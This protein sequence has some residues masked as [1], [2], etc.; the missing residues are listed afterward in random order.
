M[1]SDD[2]TEDP[3]N[4]AGDKAAAAVTAAFE[5]LLAVNVAAGD[6]NAVAN[7]TS[8]LVLT[9]LQSGPDAPGSLGVALEG[10]GNG[11]GAFLGANFSS[12]PELMKEIG[13]V[14]NLAFGRA[15]A[16]SGTEVAVV[17]NVNDAVGET[18]H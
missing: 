10:A 9:I 17:G 11:L 5:E 6:D 8:W 16:E 7:A 2:Q 13:Y 14:G 12:I 15:L 4:L 1:A 18:K 3:L